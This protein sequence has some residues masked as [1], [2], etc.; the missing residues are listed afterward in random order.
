M[1]IGIAYACGAVFTFAL[2]VLILKKLIPVLKSKKMGQPI[3]EIG[4]RWHKNKE[5]TP[6]M[7]GIS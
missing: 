6:T 4:P 3:L 7:G 2:T 1:N 5:G